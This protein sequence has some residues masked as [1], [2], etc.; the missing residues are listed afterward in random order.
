[1]KI[2]GRSHR[3]AGAEIL[4]AVARRHRGILA[5]PSAVAIFEV[6]GADALVSSLDLWAEV[7]HEIEAALTQADIVIAFPR[8]ALHI[9]AARPL[10]V[11]LAPPAGAGAPR[12]MR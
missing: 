11:Q 12:Q 2:T 3:R 7:C 9:D 10:P 1:M 8:R 4:I 6:Y 5:E